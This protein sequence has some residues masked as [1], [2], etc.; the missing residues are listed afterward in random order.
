MGV[1]SALFV[2][3]ISIEI[4]A[5]YFSCAPL[6]I[7]WGLSWFW[8][9]AVGLVWGTACCGAIALVLGVVFGVTPTVLV[10][11]GDGV[12]FGVIVA[13]LVQN[14]FIHYLWFNGNISALKLFLLKPG[15]CSDW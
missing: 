14:M 11:L 2:W 7:W 6:R 1:I 12:V 3:S 4:N 5:M 15:D 9:G 13:P 10:V 8:L